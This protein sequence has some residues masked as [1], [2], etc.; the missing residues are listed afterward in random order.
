VTETEYIACTNLAK[1]IS[2]ESILRDVL[3]GFDGVTTDAKM[4]PIKRALAEMREGLFAVIKTDG[5]A[6]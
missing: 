6:T 4:M 1:I 5:D 3:P 2:A